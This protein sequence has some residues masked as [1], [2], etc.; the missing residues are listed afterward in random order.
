MKAECQR[1]RVRAPAVAGLFYPEDAVE[2]RTCVDTLLAGKRTRDQRPKALIV[3]HAGYVYSGDI[4]ASAYGSLGKIMT[5]V[6]RFVLLGPSHRHGF[7]GLAVPSTDAFSTP[8][9]EMRVDTAA[10]RA[11][12]KLPMVVGSDVAHSDEHS[13]EV[14]IPFLQRINP[15]ALLV[16]IVAGEATAAEVETVIDAVWGGP[17][18]LVIVSSDLS[19]YHSYGTAREMDALTARAILDCRDDLSGDQACGCVGVNGLDRV[20]R[21]RGMRTELLDL[22]NSGDTAGDRRRVVGYAAF[23]FYDD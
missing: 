10:V 8:L 12:L 19:H 6:Q 13:L 3:P 5:C 2:L 18:T 9:G 4:A 22:R 17:E 23:G 21:R 11:L 20:A 16:P 1:S 7:R 15:A 14:Q